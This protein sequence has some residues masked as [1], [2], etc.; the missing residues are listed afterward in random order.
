MKLGPKRV[1]DFQ[2]MIF[3]WWDTNRR[4]LPWRRTEDPYRILVSEVMLQQTQVSRVLPKYDEF[5]KRYPTVHD[6]ARAPAADVL[7]T[8]QGMGYNRRALY[9]KKT[10]EA[11]ITTYGGTFPKDETLLTKLPGL[12]TYTARAILVFA[13]GR[14]V[15]TVDTNIRKIITHF[16]FKDRPQKEE[17]IQAAADQL[18]PLDKSWEWHQALMDYGALELNKFKRPDPPAGGRGTSIPFRNSDRFYRGRIIDRLRE[19]DAAK[20]LLVEELSKTYQKDT[21]FIEKILLGLSK[22]GLL[23]LRGDVVSLP[24]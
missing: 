4:D 9:L 17:V 15:A 7:R 12:G 18:L 10:A 23:T 3:T 20:A 11:V 24:Q 14:N 1:R 6:L 13:F 21:E 5:I 2:E 22:D 8:W 16:F 19:G